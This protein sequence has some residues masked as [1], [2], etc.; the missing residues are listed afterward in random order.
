MIR[1]LLTFDDEVSSWGS[2]A[3][4]RGCLDTVLIGVFAKHII[5]DQHVRVITLLRHRVLVTILQLSRPLVPAPHPTMAGSFIIIFVFFHLKHSK[6]TT[7]LHEIVPRSWAVARYKMHACTVVQVIT[8]KR[9]IIIKR[10]INV[11]S[12]NKSVRCRN[13]ECQEVTIKCQSIRSEYE[14]RNVFRNCLKTVVIVIV[15]NNK[16]TKIAT[17]QLLLKTATCYSHCYHS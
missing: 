15:N 5:H 1:V 4:G 8:F 16:T 10:K 7:K 3:S 12:T 14:N 6:R 13:V 17:I 2:W 11:S 9:L